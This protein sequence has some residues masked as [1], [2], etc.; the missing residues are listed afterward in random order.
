MIGRC[1]GGGPDVIWWQQAAP[2]IPLS[3]GLVA[4]DLV[5]IGVGGGGAGVPPGE[6]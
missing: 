2:K 4:K 5:A 6:V 3:G 1:R